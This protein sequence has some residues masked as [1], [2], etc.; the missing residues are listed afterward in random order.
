MSS[1]EIAA[2]CAKILEEVSLEQKFDVAYV[3][4]EEKAHSGKYARFYI[5][6]IYMKQ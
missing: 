5:V 4:I 3:D 6:V 1:A 2:D